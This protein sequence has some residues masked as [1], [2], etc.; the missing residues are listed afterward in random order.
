M[1]KVTR[2]ARTVNFGPGP[3]DRPLW[4]RPRACSDRRNARVRA[5]IDAALA[6]AQGARNCGG[7]SR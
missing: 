3:L 1:K 5:H 6:K 4:W 2:Q 7:A